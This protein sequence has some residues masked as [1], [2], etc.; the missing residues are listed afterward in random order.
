MDILVFQV[1]MYSFC[2]IIIDI[3]FLY[4]FQFYYKYKILYIPTRKSNDYKITAVNYYL[5][6]DKTQEEVCKIFKCNPRS[7]MRWVERYKKDGNVDIHYRKPI[8]YKVKKEYVEFL[9]HE[10]KNNKTITLQELL[11]KLKDK[12]KGVDLTTTQIFRV[13]RNIK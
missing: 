1:Q 6:E 5:V 7:L 11:Q 9:L 4:L 12:Y 3:L 2:I 8:A 10:I 13:K